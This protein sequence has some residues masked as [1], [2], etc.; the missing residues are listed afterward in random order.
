[1]AEIT[2]ISA[3]GGG[4]RSGGVCWLGRQPAL[5]NPPPPWGGVTEVL[6]CGSM[7]GSGLGLLWVEV[8]IV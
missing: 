6:G 1:M 3:G 5:A 7:F 8:M 2:Y 4:S